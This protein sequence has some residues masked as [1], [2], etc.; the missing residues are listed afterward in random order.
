MGCDQP[1]VAITLYSLHYFELGPAALAAGACFGVL[2]L[3]ARLGLGSMAGLAGIAAGAC[4]YAGLLW[5]G[6]NRLA[7]TA[8]VALL[9]GR[10]R[11]TSEQG[12]AQRV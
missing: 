11:A 4:C 5:A 2:P 8:F 10:R 7:L 12:V 1:E 9:P 3:L 6:R